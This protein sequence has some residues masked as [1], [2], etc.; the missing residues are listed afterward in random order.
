MKIKFRETFCFEFRLN[1]KKNS[2]NIKL[3]TF[4]LRQNMKIIGQLIYR[5]QSE[6]IS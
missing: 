5:I 3:E 6:C 2:V 4:F 1:K